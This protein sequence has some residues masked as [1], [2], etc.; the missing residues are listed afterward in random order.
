MVAGLVELVGEEREADGEP[1][2]GVDERPGRRI[3]AEREGAAQ[4]ARVGG[5]A[6][7][8]LDPREHDERH[9][10]RLRIL[11]ELGGPDGGARGVVGPAVVAE[12]EVRVPG[13]AEMDGGEQGRIG[14]RLGVGQRAAE[15]VVEPAD[16]LAGRIDDREPGPGPGRVIGL[17]AVE[18]GDGGA[19][20][21]RTAGGRGVGGGGEEEGGDGGGAGC[22]G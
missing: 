14:G 9:G 11:R 21:V 1:A 5:L 20:E 13:D 16:S 3:G 18:A 6:E 8:L 2:R 4:H 7:Q 22:G 10:L 19:R 12:R 17:G 15:D